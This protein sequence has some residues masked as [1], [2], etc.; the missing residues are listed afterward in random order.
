MRNLPTH[1]DNTSTPNNNA[2]SKKDN[3]RRSSC[4]KKQDTER[5]S[6]NEDIYSKPNKPRRQSHRS[7]VRENIGEAREEEEVYSKPNLPPKSPHLS[8]D[9]TYA[10]K[11][12]D[13]EFQFIDNNLYS[14]QI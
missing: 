5:R 12:I 14:G 2:A 4:K 13:E 9:F 11:I 1:Y 6:D 8:T 3:D 7:G 10:T